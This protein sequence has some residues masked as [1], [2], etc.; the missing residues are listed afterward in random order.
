[1]TGSSQTAGVSPDRKIIP[2]EKIDMA[3]VDTG[4]DTFSLVILPYFQGDLVA[5]ERPELQFNVNTTQ[6]SQ[7][8]AGAG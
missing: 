3:E 7:A 1:L 5:G 2:N 6:V 4:I 8:V